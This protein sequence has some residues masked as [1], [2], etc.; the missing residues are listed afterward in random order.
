MKLKPFKE[1][2]A[3]TQE[4]KDKALAP[5]RARQVQS[6]AELEMSKLD[7]KI[8]SY[9][10]QIQEL[11]AKKEIDFDALIKA[12]DELSLAERRKKQYEKILLELFPD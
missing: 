6:R 12:M 1:I 3:M 4:L 2:I 11:C 9:E 10:A 8:V 5:I 7:E